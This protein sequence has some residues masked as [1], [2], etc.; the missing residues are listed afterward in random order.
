M[1]SNPHY[2]FA[3]AIP[4]SVKHHIHRI[5]EQVGKNFSFKKWVHPE[6]YHITLAFLG[7]SQEDKI[8][9]ALMKVRSAISEERG[10][11]LIT[12]EIGTFGKQ[13]EPRILWSGVKDSEDLTNLQRLVFR[14]CL[15][16]GFLLDTRPFKPHIT[17]G[18]K[19]VGSTPFSLQ[20]I[21]NRVKMEGHSFSA[22]DV[23]LYRTH[24]DRTP[25]Y[26]A[27]YTLNLK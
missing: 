21:K 14:A 17:I 15:D 19:F 4:Q 5:S 22:E 13:E 26:E 8:E 20:E 9:E 1:I 7:S 27:V 6:D 23:V 24:L 10:F 3:L 11:T 18:R 16:T 12:S 25:K 2:F